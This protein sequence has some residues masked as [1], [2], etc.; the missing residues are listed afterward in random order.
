LREP[1]TH[2]LAQSHYRTRGRNVWLCIPLQARNRLFAFLQNATVAADKRS[3]IQGHSV[4][5]Y[6]TDSSSL[7][8][9]PRAIMPLMRHPN[10][11]ARSTP[12]SRVN[13][14][15]HDQERLIARITSVF[16][17]CVAYNS[18]MPVQAKMKS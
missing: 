10:D 6:L 3:S 4:T 14:Y 11:P 17:R 13:Y 15:P 16:S 12:G 7:S 9:E 2:H 1:A 8:T 5:A 18:G